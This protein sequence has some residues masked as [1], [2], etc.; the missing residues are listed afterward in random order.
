MTEQIILAQAQKE[1]V[2]YALQKYDNTAPEFT[3]HLDSPQRIKGEV[4]LHSI[5]FPKFE[6]PILY[7]FY[8]IWNGDLHGVPIKL[9]S[10][11]ITAKDLIWYI[12]NGLGQYLDNNYFE[13]WDAWVDR[14][15]EGK[16]TWPMEYHDKDKIAINLD[17][18]DVKLVDTSKYSDHD[19]QEF[20]LISH[21]S[22]KTYRFKEP[23]ILSLIRSSGGYV[24]IERLR[25]NIM[26]YP[27]D[28]ETYEFGF[29][30]NQVVK[31][32]TQSHISALVKCNLIESSLHNNTWDQIMEVV[33]LNGENSY[34]KVE[35][36]NLTFHKTTVDSTIEIVMRLETLDGDF[37]FFNDASPIIFKLIFR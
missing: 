2:Y 14:C 35:F 21:N 25:P 8:F 1:D 7:R 15:L 10:A 18:L 31:V 34:N 28:P 26:L 37:I 20:K 12:R 24:E 3:F 32:P 5:Y 4:A 16:G 9:P 13:E 6:I 27:D 29:H 19:L 33:L 17:L 22:S 23:N 30:H 36:T 11:L